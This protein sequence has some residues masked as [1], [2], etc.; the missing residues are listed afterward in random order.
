MA[1]VEIVAHTPTPWR[2]HEDKPEDYEYDGN[3]CLFILA[4]DGAICS[5]ADRADGIDDTD[6][7]NARLITTAV[8]SH[9]VLVAAVKSALRKHK[10]EMELMTENNVYLPHLVRQKL[11]E[12]R[13]LL[14]SALALATGEDGAA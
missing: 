10:A 1:F 2:I 13:A 14:E 5:F 7:A 4:E 12:Y 8:N 6:R 11:D 9:E 3:S